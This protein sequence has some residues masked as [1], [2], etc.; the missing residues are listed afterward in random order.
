MMIC[1]MLSTS[2]TSE[3]ALAAQMRLMTHMIQDLI[4]QQAPK[5]SAAVPPMSLVMQR[6]SIPKRTC[7]LQFLT[8]TQPWPVC[9]L[10]GLRV[11]AVSMMTCVCV[12]MSVAAC[13]RF[14]IHVRVRMSA[15]FVLLKNQAKH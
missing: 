7:C 1:L 2:F 9:V 8:P 6:S 5:F 11:C 10:C 13:T 3:R 15:C 14:V 12:C 4:L